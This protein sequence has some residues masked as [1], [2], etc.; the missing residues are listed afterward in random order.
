MALTEDAAGDDA[1]LGVGGDAMAVGCVVLEDENTVRVVCKTHR[2]C[3]V[4]PAWFPGLIW[5]ATAETPFAAVA[6]VA[7]AAAA[8]GAGKIT[9]AGSSGGEYE[10]A[11]ADVEGQAGAEMDVATVDS[12]AAAVAVVVAAAAEGSALADYAVVV[13]GATSAWSNYRDTWSFLFYRSVQV[14]CCNPQS[15]V[16]VPWVA[17]A[18]CLPT[19][20]D[21]E[22][23]ISPVWD[24]QPSIALSTFPLAEQDGSSEEV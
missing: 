21:T 24:E 10:A 6:A 11:H 1:A 17:T 5:Q 13:A 14:A 2:G 20:L 9:V 8:D 18:T 16:H 19:D 3:G 12:G 15:D 4:V 22:A 7:A 23:P